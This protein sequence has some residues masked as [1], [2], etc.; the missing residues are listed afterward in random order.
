MLSIKLSFTTIQLQCVGRYGAAFYYV[1]MYILN[2][3]K[4]ELFPVM[5]FTE[6]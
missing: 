4:R 1:Y 6:V 3:P 5:T 2:S